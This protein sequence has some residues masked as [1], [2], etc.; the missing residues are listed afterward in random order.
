MCRARWRRCACQT[1]ADYAWPPALGALYKRN[2]LMVALAL[3][4]GLALFLVLAVMLNGTL[5][6]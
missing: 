4:A 1:Y 3:A 6:S 2:G 5:L